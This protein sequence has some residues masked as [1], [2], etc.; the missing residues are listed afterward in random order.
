MNPYLLG[1]LAVVAVAGLA[2]L[3]FGHR[4]GALLTAAC[5][6]AALAVTVV[7]IDEPAPEPPFDTKA[8][9][10]LA[11]EMG[12]VLAGRVREG[13]DVV[14]LTGP[15]R[16]DYR[17]RPAWQAGLTEGAGKRLNASVV[18]IQDL[19]EDEKFGRI[20]AVVLD[21]DALVCDPESAAKVKPVLANWPVLAFSLT[22]RGLTPESLPELQGVRLITIV[23]RVNGQLV[24]RAPT[25]DGI[26]SDAPTTA[27]AP[28]A[29]PDE[30]MQA[31]TA[32]DE[33]SEEAAAIAAATAPDEGEA[34]SPLSPQV[35]I[36]RGRQALD[37]AEP[38][39]AR[40]DATHG[41]MARFACD[42]RNLY[43]SVEV[44]SPSP[45]VNAGATD[46]A[47][48]IQGGNLIDLQL[49]TDP[50]ANP[51]RIAPEPGDLRLLITRRD[52]K[53]VAMLYRPRDKS[54]AG[55]PEVVAMSHGK[56]VPFDTV[57]AL[58]AF[59]LDYQPTATGFTAV[60]TIRLADLKWKPVAG[61]AIKLDIGYVFG[62]ATGNKVTARRYWRNDSYSAWVTKDLADMSRLEPAEWG[63]ALVD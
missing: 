10:Q 15:D 35:H 17:V 46:K 53:P 55:D 43:V 63:E 3:R 42:D 32:P 33:R 9:V 59:A 47:R 18:Q 28:S 7:N 31:A 14:V 36:V 27:S 60:A 5:A 41:L 22:D 24:Q 2:L 54:H 19:T 56:C 51:Q 61:Q 52:E 21:A 40:F 44:E 25:D 62:D 4:W 8:E 16:K 20:A 6:V 38:I 12:R 11:T 57:K 50:K 1:F 49:G 39:N 34:Q 23:S 45:M 30:T 13:G 26:T 29:E 48:L 37:K 58:D